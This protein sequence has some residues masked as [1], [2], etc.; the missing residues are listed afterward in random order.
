VVDVEA[1]LTKLTG[2]A[3]GIY[4]PPYGAVDDKVLAAVG[5]PAILWSIDTLDWKK[6]GREEL[7]RRSVGVAT[8]GDIILFHDL[9]AETVE[10]ADVVLRGLRD[11]GFTLVTVEQLFGGS[12]PAGRVTRR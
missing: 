7:A 12:V 6:P 2:R 8:P 3:V 4:R 10:N 1:L 5:Q 9:H 11:R